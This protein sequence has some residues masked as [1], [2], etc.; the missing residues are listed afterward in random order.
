MANEEPPPLVRGGQRRKLT[1]AG[2]SAATLHEITRRDAERLG[3]AFAAMEP[4]LGYGMSAE[5]LASF[6]GK[7]EPGYARFAIYLDD[8]LAGAI[9]VRETW[10]LGPYLQ[11]L[12]LL[13]G[14]QGRGLGKA[15]LDWMASQAPKGT[16]NLWLCVTASNTRARAFYERH[17]FEH[18]ALLSDLVADGKDELL[19]RRRLRS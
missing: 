16:R 18:A 14:Q 11:F 19:M 4:W 13:P 6:L 2:A 9:V 7:S 12:G 1:V 3:A 17:G 5:V 15:A 10:L 8:A